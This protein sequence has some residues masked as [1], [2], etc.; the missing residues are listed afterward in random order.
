METP[1]ASRG[2]KSGS[3]SANFSIKEDEALCQA[4]IYVNEDPIVGAGQR[5]A[6]YW[7]RII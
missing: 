3:R 2:R 1:T 4:W 6:H 7:E 5:M